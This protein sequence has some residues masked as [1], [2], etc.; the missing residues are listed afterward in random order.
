MLPSLGYTS[1]LARNLVG[2]KAN[3]RGTLGRGCNVV[4]CKIYSVSLSSP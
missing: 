1:L 3:I 4:L 2:K